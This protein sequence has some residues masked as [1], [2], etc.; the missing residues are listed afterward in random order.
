LIRLLRTH[1]P[2][3]QRVLDY[4]CGPAA[5]FVELLRAAGFEAEGYDP[6]FA[7]DTALCPPY[8]AVVS[9]ETV[10]HFAAPRDEF[11]SM[12]RLLRPSGCLLLQTQWHR[13]QQTPPD[14]WYLRDETHVSIYSPATFD[15]IARNWGLSVLVRDEPGIIAYQTCTS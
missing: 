6:M 4:G 15:Y 7:A 10:E 13:G 12:C 14:W 9:V 8:D 11:E 1:A 5:V 2:K 3:A